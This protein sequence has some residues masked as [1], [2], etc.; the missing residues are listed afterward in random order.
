MAFLPADAP[1]SNSRV[2]RGKKLDEL[3]LKEIKNGRL[4]MFACLGFYAQAIATGKGPVDNWIDHI[5][6]PWANNFA[7]NGVSLPFL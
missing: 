7:T 2:F 1:L 3:K 5:S 4:A 6:D